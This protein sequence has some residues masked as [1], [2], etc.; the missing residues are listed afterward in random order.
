MDE[1]F[2]FT[3][4]CCLLSS[5]DPETTSDVGMEWGFKIRLCRLC[6]VFPVPVAEQSESAGTGPKALY[7]LNHTGRFGIKIG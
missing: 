6:P 4:L 1:K 2:N 3:T 5:F 7:E